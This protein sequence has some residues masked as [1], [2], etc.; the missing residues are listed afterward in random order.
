LKTAKQVEN[1]LVSNGFGNHGYTVDDTRTIPANG[2]F[3]Q[4][5]NSYMIWCMMPRKRVSP[6]QQLEVL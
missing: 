5:K 1:E 2:K 6:L 4:S 3:S